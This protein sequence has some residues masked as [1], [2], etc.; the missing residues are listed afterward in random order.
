MALDARPV[1]VVAAMILSAIMPRAWPWLSLGL[2]ALVLLQQHRID[3]RDVDLAQQRESHAKTLQTQA[4]QAQAAIEK[5]ARALLGHAGQQ[6]ENTRDYTQKIAALEA[7]RTADADRISRLQHDIRTTATAHAQA[8]SNAAACADLANR[9]QH[10]GTLTAEGAA[11]ADE[12]ISLVQQRDAQV[13][14]LK[15][16]LLLDRQLLD[17]LP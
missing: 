7:A 6:Q 10:L 17:A 11:V 8:A 15:N 2:A 16:Q 12:L 13:D 3:G 14:A 4:E 9:H 1:L 5:K